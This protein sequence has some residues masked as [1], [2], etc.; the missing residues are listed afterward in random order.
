MPRRA[1]P[2]PK[3]WCLV[4]ALVIKYNGLET[5]QT[6]SLRAEGQRRRFVT[7]VATKRYP[8]APPCFY[9]ERCVCEWPCAPS[10]A[11]LGIHPTAWLA[12]RHLAF[13]L[14]RDPIM[15]TTKGSL[16]ECAYSLKGACA[17]QWLRPYTDG[18]QWLLRMMC[19][20]AYALRLS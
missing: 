13:E 4:I 15:Q 14:P 10:P 5:S 8:G 9:G 20:C 7:A 1:N 6:I 11:L 3:L 18:F 17:G 2:L 16:L 12:R 19:G